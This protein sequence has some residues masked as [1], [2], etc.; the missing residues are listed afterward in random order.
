MLFYWE[1]GNWWSWGG[2][3]VEPPW[4]EQPGIGSFSLSVNVRGIISLGSPT[5]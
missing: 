4:R 3:K 2:L 1:I 5:H